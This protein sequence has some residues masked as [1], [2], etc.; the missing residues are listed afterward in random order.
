MAN[1]QT[2]SEGD[3]G[4]AC[5]AAAKG[6][7]F[8]EQ[9]R[10]GGPMNRAIHATTAKKRLIGSVDDGIHAE[11]G[12]IGNDDVQRRRADLSLEDQAEA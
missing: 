12:D 8:G 5:G 6:A 9:V 2:V 1:R 11:R 10:A 4:I 3:F 7:A